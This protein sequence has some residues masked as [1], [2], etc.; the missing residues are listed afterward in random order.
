MRPTGYCV[1]VK[2]EIRDYSREEY[3][4][5]FWENYTDLFGG[6]DRFIEVAPSIFG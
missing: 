2:N 1:P 3:N 4:K 6:Y 5:I